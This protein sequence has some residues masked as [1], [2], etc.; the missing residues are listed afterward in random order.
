[1]RGFLV[2]LFDTHAHLDDGD[3]GADREAVLERARSSGVRLIVNVGY[4]LESS[5]FSVELAERHDMIYAAV[6]I[7]PH[8]AAEVPENYLEVLE[9]LAGHRKV[10]ALGEMGLDYYRDLSPRPVQQKVFREQLLLAGRLNMPV[11]IHD[12]DAHGDLLAILKSEGLGP[13][14]GVMHCFSGS[15]EMAKQCLAMG[16]Y[17]SIAGPVTFPNAPKL[18]DIAARVPLDRLLVETDAPYLTPVPHR[19]KRNEPAHVRFTVAEI[20]RLRGMEAEE[21]ARVCAANGRRLFRIGGARSG[22]A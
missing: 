9:K 22:T 18:K 8:G 20:A 16:F 21:L 4:D 11:V 3:Y 5:R 17:I 13:A 15:W 1:M 12:R 14:G 6:G 7:H 10:V 2:E 19:G